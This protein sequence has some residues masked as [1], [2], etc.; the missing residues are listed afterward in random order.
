MVKPKVNAICRRLS[1]AISEAAIYL[2]EADHLR[3]GILTGV[4][5]RAFSAGWDFN[6]VVAYAGQSEG[7]EPVPGGFGG[8]TALWTLKKPLIAGV[9]GPA[10]GGGF[11]LALACDMIVMAEHAFFQLPEMQRGILPD[12]GGMQ[13]LPR[14]LPYNVAVEMIYTGR[15]MHSQEALR[16]GLVHSVC[17]GA[18]LAAQTRALAAE[19]AKGAPLAL[20]AFKE[21]MRAIDH[22]PVTQAMRTS[23]ANDKGLETYAAMRTSQDA[24][25]GP[26]AFLER[27]VPVWQG[28]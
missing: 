23:E 9:N 27:R 5:Q 18:D 19:I 1:R 17:P 11:E 6:E 14:R 15:Q 12:A 4:G 10:I 21:V 7:V 8:I 3:V 16:W 13:R 25:E 2:Q 20:Q 22:M 26:R 28:R 24:I